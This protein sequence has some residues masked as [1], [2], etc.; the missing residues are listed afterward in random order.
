LNIYRNEIWRE[1]NFGEEKV[2][3]K[4]EISNMG[5]IKSYAVDKENGTIIKGSFIGG[6]NTINI[7]L[8]GNK[9]LNRYVHKLV[10]ETFLKKDKPDM[11][12]VIHLDYNKK[13]NHVHNLKWVNRDDLYAHNNENPVVKK[14]RTTGY[15]LDEN[16]VRIIKKL[17]A[18]KK[19]RLNIIAKRFN[20]THTQ[21]NRI[22]SG[23][24]WGHVKIEDED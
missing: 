11:E 12:F 22:R 1:I 4:Y 3:A 2:P 23:E 6:Y 19:T 21:L 10:A 18:S 15:K 7:R 5:R 24:N 16:K 8:P 14:T 9:T 17:V 13:N 20:I